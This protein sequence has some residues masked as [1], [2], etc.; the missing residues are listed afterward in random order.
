[1]LCSNSRLGCLADSVYGEP[2]HRLF[3]FIR[4]KSFC[5]IHYSSKVWSD[6][7]LTEA[8]CTDSSDSLG[9]FSRE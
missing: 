8:P 7:G 3:C 5:P 9:L 1:M 4:L 2:D 6:N